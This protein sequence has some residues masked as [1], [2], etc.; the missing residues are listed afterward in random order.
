MRPI[1]TFKLIDDKMICVKCDNELI[2]SYKYDKEVDDYKIYLI[3][4]ECGTICEYWQKNALADYEYKVKRI[5]QLKKEITN[6]KKDLKNLDTDF[7]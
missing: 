6:D 5:T 4:P 3:C 2:N 1:D 7:I